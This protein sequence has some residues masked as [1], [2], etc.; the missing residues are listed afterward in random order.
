MAAAE[1]FAGI[2]FDEIKEATALEVNLLQNV[3]IENFS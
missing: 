3:K 1:N 2:D